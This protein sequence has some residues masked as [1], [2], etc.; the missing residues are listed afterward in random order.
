MATVF[1]FAKFY[2]SLNAFERN[3]MLPA[4]ILNFKKTLLAMGT[5]SMKVAHWI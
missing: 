1:K 2:L 3:K 5:R 4:K